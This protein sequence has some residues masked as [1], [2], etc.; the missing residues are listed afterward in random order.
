M[1]KVSGSGCVSVMI[2]EGKMG[3][4]IQEVPRGR[5]EGWGE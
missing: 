5:R 1:R 4:M 2:V 3:F